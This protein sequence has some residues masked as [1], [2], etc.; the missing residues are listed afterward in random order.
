GQRPPPRRPLEPRPAGL[1][2]P[3]QQTH[4]PQPPT[5]NPSPELSSRVL[6]ARK[7]ELIVTGK[8]RDGGRQR[9]L[10][11]HPE[12][13]LA[14]AAWLDQRAALPG[15]DTTA[16]FLNLRGGRLT[17]R[18][19]R[20]VITDLGTNADLTI[21]GDEF[22]PHVL[23]HTFATQLV[24]QGVDLV[25]VADLMGHSRLETTRIYTQ[26]TDADRVAALGL[27]LTDR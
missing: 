10:P 16:V 18:A 24:R 17:D 15:A 6:S 4:P 8:G 14:L 12:L 22:S 13:R 7:G 5:R 2:T 19:A 27:L 21:H 3:H 23:R 1:H 9:T 25:V 20:T 26:P 11:I